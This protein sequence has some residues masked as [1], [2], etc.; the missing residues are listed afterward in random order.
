MIVFSSPCEAERAFADSVRLQ[1]QMQRRSK[2]INQI[3]R[4]EE[5]DGTRTDT[6]L[7]NIDALAP[8]R[9]KSKNRRLEHLNIQFLVN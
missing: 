5:L 3:L 1:A 2:G 4:I 8:H 6:P 9:L 7:K